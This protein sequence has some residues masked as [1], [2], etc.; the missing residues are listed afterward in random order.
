MM[1]YRLDYLLG[2]FSAQS[3]SLKFHARLL[4]GAAVRHACS[5]CT[6]TKIDVMYEVL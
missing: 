6:L 2:N 4:P 3:T 5:L 1:L